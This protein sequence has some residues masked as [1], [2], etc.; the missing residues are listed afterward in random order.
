MRYKLQDPLPWFASSKVNRSLW[1]TECR[2]CFLPSIC[3]P[4][5]YESI[6]PSI[7]I[8]LRPSSQLE[9]TAA[10][11]SMTC[12]LLAFSS[13]LLHFSG[14]IYKNEAIM[15]SCERD[16]WKEWRRVVWIWVRWDEI[17][18]YGVKKSLVWNL[19]TLLKLHSW[20]KNLYIFVSNS[21]K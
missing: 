1:K 8:P 11:S 12:S 17:S 14:S 9:T 4:I 16:L 19:S 7:S 3:T 5:L 21:R 18:R 2:L 15:W 13:N 6:Q 10:R 20:I